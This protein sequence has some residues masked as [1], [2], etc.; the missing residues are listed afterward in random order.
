MANLIVESSKTAPEDIL[1]QHLLA[2]VRKQGKLY[3]LIIEQVHGGE[4]NTS[5]YQA[6]VF[7]IRPG[8]VRRVYADGRPDDLIRGV[9]VIGT[10]MS[11]LQRITET[12]NKIEVFNGYCG[13]ESGWV[14]QANCCPSVLVD[15]LEIERE[16]PDKGIARIL[17]P[18]PEHPENDPAAKESLINALNP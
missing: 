1:R 6:Q 15:S 8:I 9:R 4:T 2:E 16:I 5:S 10:P 3:G 13:A 18:P 11:V 17:P 7:Q 12:A 14:P